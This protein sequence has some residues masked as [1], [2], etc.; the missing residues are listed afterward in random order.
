[1]FLH[2]RHL[3]ELL[4]ARTCAPA[5]IKRSTY[6]AFSTRRKGRRQRDRYHVLNRRLC[7]PDEWL[8]GL[9]R[10][11]RGTVA[12]TRLTVGCALCSLLQA[13]VS[14]GTVWLL[15]TPLPYVI[16]PAITAWALACAAALSGALVAGVCPVREPIARW[17]PW[18]TAA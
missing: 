13:F 14:G 5:H 16:E 6:G 9:R 8:P 12:R 15:G 17:H 4:A 18:G 1:P 3:L 2:G 11:S 10:S 7:D